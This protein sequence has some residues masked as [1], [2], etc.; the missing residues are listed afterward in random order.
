MQ[1]LVR[2]PVFSTQEHYELLRGVRDLEEGLTVV[3]HMR[4]GYAYVDGPNKS[5][6]LPLGSV[7]RISA[8]EPLT[9]LG[10]EPERR[11]R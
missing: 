6:P 11:E 8:A 2:E 9:I 5:V 4:D 10:L 1:Y 3:S 7:L